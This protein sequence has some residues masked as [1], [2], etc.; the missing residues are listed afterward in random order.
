MT[1]CQSV[2]YTQ[3]NTLTTLPL[4]FIEIGWGAG[5]T[6]ILTVG[7]YDLFYLVEDQVGIFRWS[8]H[9]ERNQLREILSDL[10]LWE[11]GHH[12]N[13]ILPSLVH[14]MQVDENPRVALLEMNTLREEHRCVAMGVKGKDT[15]MQ[16]FGQHEFLRLV[17]QPLEEGQARL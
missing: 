3:H 5:N 12:D 14:L 11:V 16:L 8:F 10:R 17:Y 1:Q 13:S 2:F 4:V 6:Q 15:V 7:T 9:I